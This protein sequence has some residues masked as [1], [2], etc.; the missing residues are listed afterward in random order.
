MTIEIVEVVNMDRDKIAMNYSG[1]DIE[2]AGVLKQ[3]CKL[4]PSKLMIKLNGFQDAKL[5]NI[6]KA[7]E[8]L[9]SLGYAEQEIFSSWQINRLN[10]MAQYSEE[11]L[12]SR[13][14]KSYVT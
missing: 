8:R 1:I 14:K 13:V 10:K 7:A 6:I 5:D 9:S 2:F 12:L 11:I 4:D 3:L